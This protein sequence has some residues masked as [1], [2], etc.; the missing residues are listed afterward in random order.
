MSQHI[1]TD[2][3]D[4]HLWPILSHIIT[5]WV[6]SQLS[7]EVLTNTDLAAR[8]LVVRQKQGPILLLHGAFPR[9]RVE[10]TCLEP[11]PNPRCW[12]VWW[13][14]APELLGE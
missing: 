11:S 14:T 9:R 10:K 6:G 8:T 1:P 7:P 4:G 13:Y 2:I 12:V 5:I 3:K